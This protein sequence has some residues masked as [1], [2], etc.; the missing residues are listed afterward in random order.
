MFWG[1]EPCSSYIKQRFEGKAHI[2]LQVRKSWGEGRN[3]LASRLL[4]RISHQSGYQLD[5]VEKVRGRSSVLIDSLLF[6]ASF[7]RRLSRKQELGKAKSKSKTTPV[8]GS[9]VL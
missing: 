3:Q 9:G 5:R 7:P 1:I 4:G 2:H 6:F 8:T